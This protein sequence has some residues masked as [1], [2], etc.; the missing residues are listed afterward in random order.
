MTDLGLSTK[1]TEKPKGWRLHSWSQ[2]FG[3]LNHSKN[4]NGQ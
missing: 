2:P 1:I 3:D 4:F